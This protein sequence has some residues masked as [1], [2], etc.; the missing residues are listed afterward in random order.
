MINKILK[1][2]NLELLKWG[3]QR[4]KDFTNCEGIQTQF[5][6]NCKIII[7]KREKAQKFLF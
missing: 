5:N 6:F 7:Q 1:L 3:R 4:H 2:R